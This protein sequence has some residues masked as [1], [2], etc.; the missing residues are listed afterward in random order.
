MKLYA[1]V[2]SMIILSL[3]SLVPLDNQ[4]LHNAINFGS[5]QTQA[6]QQSHRGVFPML[7]ALENPYI[8]F[9]LFL[10]IILLCVFIFFF[11]RLLKQQ[12]FLS[13]PSPEEPD[14]STMTAH[15]PFLQPG[16]DYDAHV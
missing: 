3:L 2:W 6:A 14:P 11:R 8:L 9:L 5:T 7:V 15:L 1:D 16:G 10:A 4:P 12:K 13:H